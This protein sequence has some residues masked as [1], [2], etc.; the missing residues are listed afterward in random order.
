MTVA[1]V[2]AP[3][4]IGQLAQL[5]AVE[6]AVGDGDPQH[7]RVTLDIK[8]VLEPQRLEVVVAEFA[9]LV[10]LNLAGKLRSTL[11]EARRI[12][13]VRLVHGSSGRASASKAKG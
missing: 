1:P 10:A 6:H 7:R 3:G 4:D 11:F 2:V 13:Y 8:A 9:R 12:E 5:I